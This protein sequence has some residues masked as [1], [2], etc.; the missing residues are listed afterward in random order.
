MGSP[1]LYIPQSRPPEKTTDMKLIAL[2]T[3]ILGL[4]SFC[5]SLF[6]NL[7]NGPPLF[8]PRTDCS[9]NN[10]CRSGLCMS[11]TST[12]K[13][14]LIFNGLTGRRMRGNCS[15]G[16]RQC[17]ECTRDIHCRGRERCSRNYRCIECS[18]DSECGAFQECSAG[19]CR[20]EDSCTVDSQCPGSR[21]CRA[22][23]C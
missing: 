12:S 3:I 18:S 1:D 20:R 22:G 6:S 11:G 10:Q 23:T 5:T 2:C 16:Y 13:L 8:T 9:S 21:E 4:V 14:C 7:F 15:R 19:R 17:A